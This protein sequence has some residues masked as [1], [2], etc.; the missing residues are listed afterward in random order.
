M[1]VIRESLEKS[2]GQNVIDATFSNIAEKSRQLTESGKNRIDAK[3]GIT[4]LGAATIK[5]HTFYGEKD[6]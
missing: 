5:P 3:T 6:L 2:L 4:S 1:H